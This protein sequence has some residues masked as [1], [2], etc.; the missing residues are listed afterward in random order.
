MFEIDPDERHTIQFPRW[1]NLILDAL[2]RRDW[3]DLEQRAEIMGQA[4]ETRQW[5][6]SW[7]RL[8]ETREVRK[9]K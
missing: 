7:F 8:K 5:G 1:L 3:K 4:T 2:M 9:L 6:P